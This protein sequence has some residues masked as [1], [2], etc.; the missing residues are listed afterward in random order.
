MPREKNHRSRCIEGIH[1]AGN[2]RGRV[3]AL[4]IFF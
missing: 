1:R 2:G 4:V 3:A